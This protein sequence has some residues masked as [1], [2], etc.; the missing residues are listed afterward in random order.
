MCAFS[1]LTRPT[2]S[3]SMPPA[4][5]TTTSCWRP[6]P[7]SIFTSRPCCTPRPRSSTTRW[8]SW[9]PPTSTTG[10]SASTSRWW[11]PST[12]APAWP[13]WRAPLKSTWRTRSGRRFA[14]RSPVSCSACSIQ[15]RGCWPPSSEGGTGPPCAIASLDPV[16]GGVRRQP[17]LHQCPE[18]REL[19]QVGVG[20]DAGRPGVVGDPGGP[21]GPRAIDERL[22]ALPPGGRAGVVN[23]A[24]GVPGVLV[25]ARR[26]DDDDVVRR[27]GADGVDPALDDRLERRP[28]G[29]PVDRLVER[30][31]EHVAVAGE[32]RRDV[33]PEGGRVRGGG[34]G[35]G[36]VDL[37]MIDDHVEALAGGVVDR[38][39]EHLAV[40]VGGAHRRGRRAARARARADRIRQR[41]AGWVA[42]VVVDLRIDGEPYHVPLHARG[43]QLVEAGRDA[44]GAVSAVRVERADVDQRRAAE[45]DGLAARILQLR[46]IYGE[47]RQP[48]TST[49]VGAAVGCPRIAR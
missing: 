49:C 40:V 1:C 29:A 42:A 22:K 7:R 30:L 3:G 16:G 44:R 48:A 20:E 37:V 45:D 15:R 10:A 24:G 9:A 32:L 13:T 21:A 19:G 5:R 27:D 47:A 34:T 43:G 38:G 35:G 11:P 36:V 39:L 26:R 46:S 12:A 17:G 31:V 6:A 4:G 25:V 28:A 23:V 41:R 2:R 14:R 18:G 33:G 8:R